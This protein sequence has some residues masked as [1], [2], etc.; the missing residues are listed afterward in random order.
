[1]AKHALHMMM[2]IATD[3]VAWSVCLCVC[4]CVRWSGS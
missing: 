4:L 1:M 2:V 3:E